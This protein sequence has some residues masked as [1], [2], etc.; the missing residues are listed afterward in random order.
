MRQTQSS[1]QWRA[2]PFPEQLFSLRKARNLSQKALAEMVKVHVT[3]I[4]RYET[5]QIQ[6]NLAVLKRLAIALNVS[7]DTLIFDEHERAP[8]DEGVR[9]ILQALDEFTPEELATVKNVLQGLVLQHQ[10][11]RWANAS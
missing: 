1:T 10:A 5:G 9:L 8:K 4:Q 7:A 2:M 3:Q 6:P 11:R